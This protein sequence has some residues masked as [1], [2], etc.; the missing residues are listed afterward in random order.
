MRVLKNGN[1]IQADS[2]GT[3]NQKVK[4]IV[5]NIL[6]Q[7]R[8]WIRRLILMHIYGIIKNKKQKEGTLDAEDT[9]C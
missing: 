7:S 3:D 8:L 9:D 4:E 6:P 2:R 1:D 5:E